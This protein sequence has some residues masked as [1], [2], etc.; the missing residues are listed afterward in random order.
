MTD[1]IAAPMMVLSFNGR[2]SESK[3]G[4]VMTFL[5]NLPRLFGNRVRQFK[6]PGASLAILRGSRVIATA[7]SGVTSL[8][9]KIRVTEDTLFQIG[10][11]T[12]P[13][14]TTLAM[15]LVDEGKLDLDKPIWHYLPEF[16]VADAKVSRTVT[17][18]HLLSHQSGIDGDFFVDSG[19]GDDAAQRLIDMASM[20][21]NQ[22]PLG[23]Q[24]S[25]C[26][27][28][29]VIVGR[30]TEKLRDKPWD[31]VLREHLFHP[32]GMDQAFSRPE[33]G[34]RFSCA[35]GHV[36]S[37]RRKGKWYASRVPYL[38]QGQR[39]AGATPTMT[40]SN[41]LKF[42]RMHMNGGKNDK[43]E[44]VLS[45]KSVN[46][47]QRQ[48]IR[49]PKFFSRSLTGW[50]LGWMLMNYGGEKVYGH[51]GGTIGQFA[52]LRVLPKKNLA[53]A[54]L[55]NGGD[56]SDLYETMY[57]DIFKSL[58]KVDLPPPPVPDRSM[59]PKLGKFEGSYRNLSGTFHL[60]EH[61]GRLTVVWGSNEGQSAIP[62]HSPLA[63]IGKDAAMFDTDDEAL[64]RNTLLFSGLE[65]GR[66]QYLCF[67]T[68]IYRRVG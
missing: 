21:P 5:E 22:F 45:A 6:V 10:S 49:A 40:A 23:E 35:I 57:R 18:R 2:L 55:T 28:G 47:M 58:A 30:I 11:I 66:M 38:S 25:Y 44:T 34:I 12:K 9:T 3:Q 68:R 20:M 64:N 42:A 63:F 50:G 7:A 8:D 33:D 17:T 24:L 52:F 48:Q 60:K 51:D 32:L 54:M 53:V 67:G 61:A 14:T 16:R 59:T 56:A 43:G 27:L 39:A 36:P 31:D 15:Q 62:D 26:N 37:R 4:D 13:H 29:F 65:N 19:R 46:A 41:L 1:T